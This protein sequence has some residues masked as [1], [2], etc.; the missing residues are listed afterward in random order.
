MT[1]L[2]FTRSVRSLNRLRHIAQVLTQ[3]GFGHIVARIDLSRFV[4]VQMLRRKRVEP[5]IE[6]ASAL[7][8]RLALV[9]SDLGPTFV[10][11]AQMLTTRPDIVPE[12]VLVE[13]ESLQDEV[14]PFD[15]AVARQIIAEELGQPIE[16]GFTSLDETPLASGS[17]GQVYRATTRSGAAVVVK[18]RRPGIEQTIELDM[19]LLKWLAESLENLMPELRIYRPRMIIQEFEQTLTRELDFINEAASTARLAEAFAD[20]PDLRIPHVFWAL[21][22]PRV[23]TLEALAGRNIEQLLKEEQ[24]GEAVIDR[25]A[26]ARRLLDTVL[27]QI[28]DVGLF[29]ADPHPGNIL[30]EPPA[31]VGLIDFGQIGSISDEMMT[32]IVVLVLAAVNREIDVIIDALG[33]MGALGPTTDRRELQ[34]ALRLLMDKYYGLPLKRFDVGT[35]LSEFADVVRRQDVSIPREVVILVKALSMA[36]GVATKLD[37]DLDVLELLKPRLKKTLSDRLSPPRLMRAAT[38]SAWHLFSTV[39]HVP[40]NLREALRRLATGAWELR[41]KHEN[42]DRLAQEMD[43]SSNRLS[44]AVVIAAIIVG[45][46]IV[47]STDSTDTLFGLEVQ[48]YGLIGYLVAGI[49]GLALSWAIFRSG[50]LH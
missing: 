10:K 15:T 44:F 4:P 34:R 23:L 13:L 6:G 20:D 17:I 18:V 5:S 12:A 38:V 41:I 36:T 39:R 26:V 49:L 21:T 40:G 14:P 48:S 27:R 1:P 46:S 2:Q 7:G 25:R 8:R 35:V 45:S 32:Q 24:G 43:R 29:H 42:I 3:H 11:L 22:G 33:D 28:F 37:P 47:M 9:C 16:E 19:Q 30:V 50:R 31:T